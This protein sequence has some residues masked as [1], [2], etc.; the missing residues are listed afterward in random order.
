MNK[1]K[2]IPALMTLL[3]SLTVSASV[4]Q[5]SQIT[6]FYESVGTQTSIGEELPKG[7]SLSLITPYENYYAVHIIETGE[8]GFIPTNQLV[9]SDL[10]INV[11]TSA[12]NYIGTPYVYGGN[13][14]VNGIDCSGF[15]QQLFKLHGVDIERTANLQYMNNGIFI[16]EDQLQ[17][18]DLVFFGE[19]GKAIHLGI[20]L[21][22]DTI[23]HAS[24]SIHGVVIDGM[25]DSGFPPIL[26]FKRI[27]F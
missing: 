6:T 14:L 9:Q 3:S 10:G 24:T 11:A 12:L 27:L 23:I 8:L 5:T 25:Y 7:T 13:D 16:S 19:N 1:L 2:F 15:S 22:E 26:G 18:G 20:Y 17:P 21:Y 4:I